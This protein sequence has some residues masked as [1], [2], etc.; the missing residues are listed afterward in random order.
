MAAKKEKTPHE[1]FAEALYRAASDPRERKSIYDPDKNFPKSN[2]TSDEMM[3]ELKKKF[4]D[5]FGPA[6]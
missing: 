6:D 1:R 4:D 2:T 5:L 3:D